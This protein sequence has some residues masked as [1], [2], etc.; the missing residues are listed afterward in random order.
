MKSSTLSLGESQLRREA[1]RAN[2]GWAGLL[3][4][5]PRRRLA[6]RRPDPNDRRASLVVLTEA[7]LVIRPMSRKAGGSVE[8]T[9][10]DQLGEDRLE[11]LRA[12]LIE[13]VGYDAEI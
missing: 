4:P 12:A 13:L 8:R 2:V 3:T 9:W 11:V 5:A 7:G 1:H 6:E 10:A